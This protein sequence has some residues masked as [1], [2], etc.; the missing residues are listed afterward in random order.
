MIGES[1][2]PCQLGFVVADIEASM[3][4]WINALGAGPFVYVPEIIGTSFLYR[5]E[6]TDLDMAVAL[7]YIGDTQIELI[8]Q[9]NSA[10]SPYQ[11][12]LRS[13]ATGV[14][15]IGFWSAEPVA[16]GKKLLMEGYRRVFIG[17]LPGAEAG[18]IYYESPVGGMPMIEVSAATPQKLKAYHGLQMRAR[19]G[20]GAQ[21]VR[22]YPSFNDFL[23]DAT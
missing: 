19:T 4:H 3:D 6:P 2:W 17:N 22:T 21:P 8:Q 16:A 7:G 20:T 10:P 13:G 11:D 9:R 14:Q 15:H 12:F 1:G 5:D 23:A 18:S